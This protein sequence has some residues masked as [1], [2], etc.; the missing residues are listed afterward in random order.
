MNYLTWLS[1]KGITTYSSYCNCGGYAAS[2]NGRSPEHPHL[3][4]CDQYEEY[5]KLYSQYQKDKL[6]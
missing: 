3:S 5:E 4:W 1:E 6:K 2:M